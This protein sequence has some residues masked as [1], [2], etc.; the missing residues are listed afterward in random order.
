MPA[1]GSLASTSGGLTYCR[2]FTIK[3]V[4]TFDGGHCISK[5]YPYV[6]ANSLRFAHVHR[7]VVKGRLNANSGKTVQQV[8]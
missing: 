7:A 1:M 4:Y 8:R 3:I 6:A 5:T 2:A